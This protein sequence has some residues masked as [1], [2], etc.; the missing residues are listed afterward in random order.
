MAAHW[1]CT[2][3]VL[4]KGVKELQRPRV[5]SPPPAAAEEALQG[6]DNDNENENKNK[7]KLRKKMEKAHLAGHKI[8]EDIFQSIYGPGVKLSF[9]SI[10]IIIAL[11]CFLSILL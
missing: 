8:D 11:H 6:A 10:L 4:Q 3:Q 1:S 2:L 9:T 7:K 5:P